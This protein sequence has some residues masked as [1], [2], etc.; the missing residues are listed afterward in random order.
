MGYSVQ[1]KNIFYKIRGYRITTEN[2]F[3]DKKN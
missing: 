2:G 3:N 1:R